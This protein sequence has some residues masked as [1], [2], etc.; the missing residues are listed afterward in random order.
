MLMETFN[1]NYQ[2]SNQK[3]MESQHSFTSAL[4]SARRMSSGLQ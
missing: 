1:I 2:S 3:L 4:L